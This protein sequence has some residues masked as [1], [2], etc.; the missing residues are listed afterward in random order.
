MNDVLRTRILRKLESLPE[1]RIYQVLDYIEFLESR[2]NRGV[3]DDATA[4]QKLAERFE[5]GLRKRTMNPSNLREAFQLI[6]A[7]DRVLSSVSNAGRQIL[8]ELQIPPEEREGERGWDR[9]RPERRRAEGDAPENP[10]DSLGDSE[11]PRSRTE[12][13]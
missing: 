13:G 7:A 2:Y 8:D 9:E 6:S 11:T 4:L 1:D 12:R 10:R 5:D 3:V